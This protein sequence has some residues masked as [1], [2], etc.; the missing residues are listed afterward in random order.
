[1]LSQI[2]QVVVWFPVLI[3]LM[4]L[5]EHQVHKRLMHKKPRFLFLRRLA[6]RNK[7]FMR[8]AVEHHGHYRQAFHDDAVPYGEDR[9][10]RLNLWEG[11][12][13]SL[14][15]CLVLVWFSTTAALLL[16]L[17]V[18]LH[19]F[20]WNQIHMEMHKPEKRFFANWGLY[21]F[22]A[23][24][25][26]LHHRYPDKNFNVVFPIGDFVF[27]TV[28]KPTDADWESMRAEGL[29]TRNCKQPE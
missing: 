23:R 8:H 10:I 28:A 16:P 13:E 18:C 21:K 29:V 24:H 2:L 9:G 4:T 15:V 12:V 27:G 1:M 22:M 6:V 17:V 11:I 19:H 7:I 3:V 14:P 20:I 5:V 25:H 26:Y